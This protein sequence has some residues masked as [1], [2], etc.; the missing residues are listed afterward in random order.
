MNLRALAFLCILFC[1]HASAQEIRQPAVWAV[2]DADSTIYLF[3]TVH[4]GI[5]GDNWGGPV[6]RNALTQAQEVWTEIDMATAQADMG[7]LIQT[8]GV[9]QR[10]LSEVAGPQ[11]WSQIVKRGAEIGATPE[12]MNR[13]RPWVLSLIFAIPQLMNN[14]KALGQGADTMIE[15]HAQTNQQRR[16][17]L[18]TAEQQVQMFA[19]LSEGAQLA[20]L[21]ETLDGRDAT[22][23]KQDDII[24]AWAIGDD[25]TI[26]RVFIDTVNGRHPEIYNALIRQRNVAW[27]EV[28]AREMAGSGIDFVAVGAGHLAGPDGVQTMLAARGFHVT[29]LTPPPR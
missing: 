28:L 8:Y 18:E 9:A 3:G 22:A 24:A 21:Y 13:V 6:A 29:R 12:G 27:T 11:R 10:P 14:P 2:T 4:L 20:M 25:A 17:T 19:N 26:A 15:Q 23:P 16:R 7:R 5:S 1:A